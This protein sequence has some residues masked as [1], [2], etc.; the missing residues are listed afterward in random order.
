MIIPLR[1][2]GRAR[3]EVFLT[4]CRLFR[5][6]PGVDKTS[7][8]V[9]KA[10]PG[11]VEETPGLVEE[12]PGLVREAFHSLFFMPLFGNEETAFSTPVQSWA[13]KSPCPT[14]R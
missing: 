14:V 12:T 9:D 5:T 4:R 11:L 2:P 7:P 10:T 8:G 6:S 1:L 13:R 3:R